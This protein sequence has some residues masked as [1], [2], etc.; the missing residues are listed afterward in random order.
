MEHVVKFG[1]VDAQSAASF[2]QKFSIEKMPS[3]VVVEEEKHFIFD[4]EVKASTIEQFAVSKV[5]SFL[6]GVRLHSISDFLQQQKQTPKVIYFSAKPTAPHIINGLARIF[7][8]SL[9]FGV[10]SSQEEVCCY[11][12]FFP[13]N[14]YIFCFIFL[15]ENSNF[16]DNMELRNKIFR[17]F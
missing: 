13:F 4:G 15:F 8:S 7:K 6:S 14:D 1:H 9:K 11:T 10:V 2:K 16:K 3:I 17:H 5:P 12:H